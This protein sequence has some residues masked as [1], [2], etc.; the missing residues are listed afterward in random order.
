[1]RTLGRGVAWLDAGTN[2]ALMQAGNFVQTVQERQGLMISCPEEIAYRVG[3]IGTEQ[4]RE[5][6]VKMEDNVYK[7]YLVRLGRG[8]SGQEVAAAEPRA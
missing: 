4:L 6:A 3:F 8:E 5:L 1:M 2:E 7:S